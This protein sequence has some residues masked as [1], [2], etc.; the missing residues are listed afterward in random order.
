MSLTSQRLL[1]AESVQ[2]NTCWAHLAPGEGV[3][4]EPAWGLG[5]R[6]ERLTLLVSPP[7]EPERGGSQPFSVYTRPRAGARVLIRGTCRRAGAGSP[8]SPL[9]SPYSWDSRVP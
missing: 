8:C 2:V 4:A 7:G 5:P 9:C 3:P 1:S 6:A